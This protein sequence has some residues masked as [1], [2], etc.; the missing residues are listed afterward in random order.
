MTKEQ[1]VCPVCGDFRFGSHQLPD[2]T[3]Q[4]ICHGYV[5]ERSCTH[6]WHQSEDEKNGVSTELNGASLAAVVRGTR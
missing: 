2:G 5:N 6:T 3:L 4:R 1:R